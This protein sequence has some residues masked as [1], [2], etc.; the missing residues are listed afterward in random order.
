VI[1]TP[2]RRKVAMRN[3]IL[4]IGRNWMLG[5]ALLAGLIGTGAATAN[6]APRDFRGPVAHGYIRGY[7][8]N[9]PVVREYARPGFGVAI[10]GPVVEGYVPPCPGE[11]YVWT[12][13]AWVFRGYRAVGPRYGY[14]HRF[15]RR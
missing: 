13:N 8:Y 11:G 1:K 10:G 4:G 14:G 5:T 7:G 2:D 9:R 12:N 3:T 6:A 15:Y